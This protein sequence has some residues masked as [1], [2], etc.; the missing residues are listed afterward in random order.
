[1]DAQTWLWLATTL[2]AALAGVGMGW[3][4]GSRQRLSEAELERDYV[5]RELFERVESEGD[6]LR[7]ELRERDQQLSALNAKLVRLEAELQASQQLLAVERQRFEE[8]QATAKHEFKAIAAQLLEEKGSRLNELQQQ[9]LDALLQ[10]LKE[11]IEDFREG[12]EQKLLQDAKEKFSLREAIENLT[13]LN[14]RLSEEAEHLARAL[15]GD[16]K[17]Q[18]DWGEWQL[19]RLLELAGLQKGLHYTTQ[20]SF[21]DGEGQR[22]RPDCIVHLPGGRHLVIDSKVSLVAWEEFCRAEVDEQRQQHLQRLLQ[23]LRAHIKGLAGKSYAQLEQLHTPDYVLLYV[24]LEPAFS[25]AMQ[26]EPALFQ[27]ALR[28]NVVLV[29]NSTLLATMKT[30]AYIWRQDQQKKSVMEIAR[31]SGKLYD[32]LVMFVADLQEVGKKIAQAQQTWAKA[33]HKLKDGERYGA[34]VLGR[35]ERIRQLGAETSKRLPSDLL[36]DEDDH[37]EKPSPPLSDRQL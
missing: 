30:V 11:K 27:E 13:M 14:E 19:E 12:I 16:V 8:L 10:P 23:H 37:T 5:R 22:K 3:W 25:A 36:P 15:K 34:T 29:T 18:G 7:D 33:M 31:Q 28:Y 17:I 4:L 32:K 26:A 35:A 20:E 1:M 21:D 24:P 2:T 6:V 9:R